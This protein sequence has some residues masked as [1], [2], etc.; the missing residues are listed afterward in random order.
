[1]KRHWIVLNSWIL[2]YR[3]ALMV[4]SQYLVAIIRVTAP[5]AQ[6]QGANKSAVTA[7]LVFICLNDAA[8]GNKCLMGSWKKFLISCLYI[9]G[10]RHILSVH[11][12]ERWG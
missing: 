3:T 12:E 4:L 1:M 9:G 11:F 7:E 6:V 10:V 2:S 8:L 5:N